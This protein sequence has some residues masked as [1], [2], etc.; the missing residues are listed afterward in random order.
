MPYAA[1]PKHM[2][3]Y[4]P[5]SDP[6]WCGEARGMRAYRLAS[7]SP[8]AVYGVI[9]Q[10]ASRTLETILIFAG[11]ADRTARTTIAHG[12]VFVV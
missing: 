10:L 9:G 8:P 3:T 7:L 1:L 6:H 12:E 5:Q 2:T 4:R 11:I